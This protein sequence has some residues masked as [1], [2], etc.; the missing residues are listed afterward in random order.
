MVE[1]KFMHTPMEMNFKKLCGKD[2][3]PS[4]ANPTEYRQLIGVLMCLVNTRP[5]IC[6]VVNNLSQHLIDPFHVHRIVAKHVLR[7]LH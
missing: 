2:A 5:D 4:L 1:C 7:Y 3:G 6:F